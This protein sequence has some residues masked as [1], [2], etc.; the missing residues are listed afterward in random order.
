[1]YL[2]QEFYSQD[3][4]NVFT[5]L[6][7][8]INTYVGVKGANG[9][10]K[11][12]LAVFWPSIGAIISIIGGTL[13]GAF[14]AR[15]AVLT[16]VDSTY[17]KNGAGLFNDDSLFDTGFDSLGAA[18]G[19]VEEVW[20][21][22][23]LG[24]S[25]LMIFAPYYLAQLLS[26]YIDLHQGDEEFLKNNGYSLLTNGFI[27][28]AGSM[29]ASYLMNETVD[30]MVGWFRGYDTDAVA[31]FKATYGSEPNW[32]NQTAIIYDVFTHTLIVL[33]FIVFVGTTAGSPWAY[34]YF[35]L[36]D[37]VFGLVEATA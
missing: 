30:R 14:S 24:V 33:F 32:D 18:I 34:V 6:M 26:E 23:Y 17:W 20:L 36:S 4:G 35:Q 21:L 29:G 5:I 37:D 15:K 13:S 28:A 10:F 19:L 11:N 12:A 25:A 16:I 3:L 2:Q 31:T 1:M 22:A 7:A 9:P 8:I 27:V